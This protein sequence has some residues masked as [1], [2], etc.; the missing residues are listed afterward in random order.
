MSDGSSVAST[1]I[2]KLLDPGSFVEIGGVITAR[3]T[4]FVKDPKIGANDGVITGHGLVDGN[5]VFVFSQDSSVLGGTIGE[6]HARKICNIFDMAKKVGAPVVGMFDSKGI[7]IMESADAAESLGAVIGAMAKASGVVP[8]VSAVFGQLG[9]GMSAMAGISDFVFMEDKAHIFVNPPDGVEGVN[10]DKYDPSSAKA[11]YEESYNVDGFGSEDEILTEI[12]ELIA[13]IPGSA[14]EEGRVE[15]PLDDM[16]RVLDPGHKNADTDTFVSLLSDNGYVFKAK[17]GCG[18]NFLTGIM[19]MGGRTVGVI[20]NRRDEKGKPGHFGARCTLKAA[21]FV[22]FLDAFSIP[23]LTIT[24]VNG[25][26]NKKLVSEF[27]LPGVLADLAV[28]L[29]TADV[30]KI[31]LVRNAQSSAYL[32][33]NSKALSADLVYAYEDSKMEIMDADI[34]AKAIAEDTKEDTDSVKKKLNDEIFGAKNYARRGYVDSLIDFADTRKYL[35][36]GFDMLYT[37]SEIGY[38]KHEAR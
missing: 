28:N 14:M 36:A 8:M 5:L 23:I 31:N 37:K 9:G 27:A 7:R 1:R 20:A 26:N 24:D 4:D 6:M 30:A 11:Q 16:N 32:F 25:Y 21:K 29:A 13:L 17:D 35:I 2:E 15:A 19:R 33:M 22:K 18:S 34:I 10:K 3:S 12:R 38:K